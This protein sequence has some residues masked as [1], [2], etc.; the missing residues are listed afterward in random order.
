[1]PMSTTC[2]RRRRIGRSS[3]L[4][5]ITRRCGRLPSRPRRRSP[6][7]RRTATSNGWDLAEIPAKHGVANVYADIGTSFAMSATANPRFCAAFTGTLI[8]GLG[9]DHVFW[10]TD[11][12]WYGS[13]QWQIEALRRLEIPEDMRKKHGF[14][15]LGPTNNH[16]K[17]SIFGLNVELHAGV[18]PWEIDGMATIKA[19]YLSG[20][21]ARSNTAY[22]YVTR[23]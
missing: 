4:G 22:G 9:A 8:K 15:E 14:A 23:G 21:P 17:A 5:F 2:P 10:G 1:M 16:V 20:S 7:S 11:S 19:A 13:P 6:N 12:V 3:A 18:M